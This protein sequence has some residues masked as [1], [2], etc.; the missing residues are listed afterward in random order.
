M[1]QL[2]V[3][4]GALSGIVYELELFKDCSSSEVWL[5]L[6]CILN[7][8]VPAMNLYSLH[9]TAITDHKHSLLCLYLCVV[10][11]LQCP[12]GLLPILYLSIGL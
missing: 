12:L 8:T 1:Q 10:F 11:N 3:E 7:Y 6:L 9:I 2:L 4:E 5:L